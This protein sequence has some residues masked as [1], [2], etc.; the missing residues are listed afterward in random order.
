MEALRR[1]RRLR[2]GIPARQAA[3]DASKRSS[4]SS[5]VFPSTTS[6]GPSTVT[7]TEEPPRLGEA[8]GNLGGQVSRRDLQQAVPEPLP[9][10]AGL[11]RQRP[12][13]DRGLDPRPD[14]RLLPARMGARR[15]D[16]RST[17]HRCPGHVP[18]WPRPDVTLFGIMVHVLSDPTRHAG[19]AAHT[20]ANSSTARPGWRPAAAIRSTR[21]PARAHCARIEQSAR[22][23]QATA[24]TSL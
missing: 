24:Q 22:A 5:T 4:G 2:E 14:H 3:T 16:D 17:S 9:P 23:A 19:H 8:P 20:C 1:H 21:P 11:P 12:L 15:R 10:V 13:G 7:G 6:A 18:W